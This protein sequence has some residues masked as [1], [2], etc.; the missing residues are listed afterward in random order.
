[1]K[2]AKYVFLGLIMMGLL[3][4]CT[5]GKHVYAQN[6]ACL[7]CINNPITGKPLNHN[8][9]APGST[10]ES[11]QAA[12]ESDESWAEDLNEPRPRSNEEK[13]TFSVPLDVDLAFVKIKREY[14]YFTEQE[15]RQ[16]WGSLA[17][18]KLKTF[19][20]AYDATPSV[21]YHMR[22]STKHEGANYIIDHQIEK[23]RAGESQI[24]LTVWVDTRSTISPSD[25]MKSV[26]VRT[27]KSLNQ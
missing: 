17:S 26:A 7:T 15:I 1:V 13:I 24:I 4:G 18:M 23:K 6:G 19:E 16:E 8:G 11:R 20:Y 22:S 27:R 2:Q 9:S 25:V 5:G 12:A 14:G 10:V 21:Y 3:S